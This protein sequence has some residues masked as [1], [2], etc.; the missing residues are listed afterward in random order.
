VR[1]QIEVFFQL[2]FRR[3]SGTSTAAADAS[4]PSQAIKSQTTDNTE[5]QPSSNASGEHKNEQEYSARPEGEKS[6]AGAD[7]KKQKEQEPLQV[8][9]SLV[10][11]AVHLA[12]SFPPAVRDAKDAP[13]SVSSLFKLDISRSITVRTLKEQLKATAAFDHV[14]SAD[15]IRLWHQERLLKHDRWP[16]KKHV[17]ESSV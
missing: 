1:G 15:H 11:P 10:S 4:S 3:E 7:E 8:L 13:F 16:L 2:Y 14:P 5:L 9:R 6:E 12:R 17:R